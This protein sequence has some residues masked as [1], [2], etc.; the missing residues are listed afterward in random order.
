MLLE[1]AVLL[2]RITKSSIVRLI[3]VEIGDM[4][5]ERVPAHLQG[6][7]SLIEQKASINVGN[8]MSE[9]TNPGPI[10]NNIYVPTRNG[11]GVI[12]TNQIGGDVD[13]KSLADLDYFLNKIY[14]ALRIPKQ[15]MGDTDDSTGFNGGSAL[16]LISSSFAKM[17]KRI[18]TTVIQSITDMI[19]LLLLDK[20]QSDY[21]GKYSIHMVEPMTEE[22]RNRQENLSSEIQMASDIMNLLGDINDPVIKLKMLKALLSN[23]IT[24][25]EVMDLIQQQ[26]FLKELRFTYFFRET[27]AP[28]TRETTARAAATPTTSLAPVSGFLVSS[29]AATSSTSEITKEPRVLVDHS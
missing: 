25:D 13:V 4:P 12:T 21:I 26:M 24:N 9:Y 8:K 22:D 6:I 23:S 20:G 11:Q 5:K 17:V 3:Q 29:S 14:G 27:A 15:Y 28:A 10:E 19:N 2:N 16:S 18:Q 1:N 7:K